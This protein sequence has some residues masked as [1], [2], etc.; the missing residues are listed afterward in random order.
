MFNGISAAAMSVPMDWSIENLLVMII[1]MLLVGGV[2]VAGGLNFV[3]KLTKSAKSS[4]DNMGQSGKEGQ[5]KSGGIQGDEIKTI[6]LPDGM[7]VI[8]PGFDE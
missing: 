4:I 5:K 7:T 2:L 6:L 8:L 1:I 3:F